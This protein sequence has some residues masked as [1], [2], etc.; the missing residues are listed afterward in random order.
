MLPLLF[1]K[2]RLYQTVR[3]KNG[4]KPFLIL[5]I[6]FEISLFEFTTRI[7]IESQCRLTHTPREYYTFRERERGVIKYR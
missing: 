5:V 1:R 2:C 4:T 3:G 6:G 7:E